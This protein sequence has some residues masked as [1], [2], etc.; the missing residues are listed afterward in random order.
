MR[1]D[2]A[3]GRVSDLVTLADACQAR[4]RQALVQLSPHPRWAFW[5]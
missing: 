2:E 4:Q 1:L 5:R 3:N